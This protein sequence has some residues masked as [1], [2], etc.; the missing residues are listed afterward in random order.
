MRTGGLR[1][2]RPDLE[3]EAARRHVWCTPVGF[4]QTGKQHTVQRERQRQKP[5]ALPRGAPRQ[6][7]R[8]QIQSWQL[9]STLNHLASPTSSPLPY[10][11]CALP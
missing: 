8:Q 3:S 6:S 4:A 11:L 9:L 2:H 5:H 7:Q 10:R 1:G